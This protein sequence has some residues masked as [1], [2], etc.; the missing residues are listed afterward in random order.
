MGKKGRETY[1]ST[2]KKHSIRWAHPYPYVLTWSLF[3]STI[4]VW[5]SPLFLNSKKRLAKP[6][7]IHQEPGLVYKGV[8]APFQ[9]AIAWKWKFGGP[10][11]MCLCDLYLAL[12][13]SCGFPLSQLSLLSKKVKSK[14][15]KG[16]QFYGK[17]K[18]VE[19]D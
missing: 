16:N 11:L 18:L 14:K 7:N 17:E 19:C 9:S 3:N 4:A 6:C 12:P 8:M 13:I 2:S 10:T 1:L 15:K 5:I